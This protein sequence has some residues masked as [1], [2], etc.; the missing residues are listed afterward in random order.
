MTGTNIILCS[1]THPYAVAVQVKNVLD[2][3]V[4]CAD[5]EFEYNCNILSGIMMFEEYGHK[6]LNLDI[7]YFINGARASYQDVVTDMKRGEEFVKHV[8]EETK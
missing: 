1:P 4:G 8:N 2:R 5:M 3:I 6:K 7:Q